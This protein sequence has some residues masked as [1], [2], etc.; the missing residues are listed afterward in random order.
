MRSARAVFGFRIG[1]WAAAALLLLAGA[2][3]NAGGRDPGWI[4]LAGVAG[5]LAVAAGVFYREWRGS[6][7]AAAIAFLV[8]V[9][10]AQFNARQ[11]DLVPQLAGLVLLAVAGL[12]GGI[13]YRS[14]AGEV[15]G[16]VAVHGRV[17]GSWSGSWRR[18][19]CSA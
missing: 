11:G 3:L 1:S 8:A 16:R 14:F 9:G 17:A 2:S 19:A 13:A 10:I 4:A 18:R 12:V 15:R 7:P 5:L 6:V